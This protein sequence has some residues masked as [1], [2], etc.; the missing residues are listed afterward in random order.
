MDKIKTYLPTYTHKLLKS[1][2]YSR[3]FS[4]R[5]NAAN[6]G[7]YNIVA[8]DPQGSALGPCL[9]VL[10]TADIPTNAQLTTSTFADDT[11]ILSRSRGP[12][13]ATN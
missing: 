10:Y 9:Y 5:C 12:T 11:A 3:V 2:L 4:V 7:N 6:S 13:Q 8:G 1:Y